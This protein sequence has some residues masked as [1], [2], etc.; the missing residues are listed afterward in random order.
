MGRKGKRSKSGVARAAGEE[1]G[2]AEGDGGGGGAAEKDFDTG[3]EA[4]AA[5]RVIDAGDFVA[6][7]HDGAGLRPTE[8]AAGRDPDADAGGKREGG[9]DLEDP[10][11]QATGGHERTIASV[12]GCAQCAGRLAVMREAHSNP[13]VHLDLIRS[14]FLVAEM[15]SLNR[16]AARLRVSQSTLTRQMR[17]LEHE[18]GGALFERSSTGVAL[19][20]AGNAL[21]SSARPALDALEQAVGEAR[22]LARGQSEELRIGYLMSAA[23]Q[24]L[25]P[26]LAGL[27]REHPKV[28]VR[29]VDLSPGEQIAALRRGEID[30]AL[31]G[32]VGGQLAREFYVRRIA[33]QPV[34]AALPET[35][36]LAGRARV[37]LAELRNDVLVGA[38]EADLPGYNR[39]VTQL[40]RKAGFRPKFLGDA[41]SLIHSF[42]VVVSDGAVSLV[43]EFAAQAKVPGVVFREVADDG[44]RWELLLAWQR[45]KLTA[46]VREML[47]LVSGP[48]RREPA[49]RT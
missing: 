43:P 39:W 24:Y 46:P 13:A 45:G 2:E 29:L 5:L 31:L 35:H 14:F 27:R 44:V 37:R 26:V 38:R 9:D 11:E 32:D 7:H 19:T 30:L 15:G 16:A 17:A 18:V 41:E 40:C 10:G 25:N 28:K 49:A 33:A 42:S 3:D 48:P 34:W 36:A 12:G 1:P 8:V 21:R 6:L 47:A 20:A 4:G 23:P 22:R